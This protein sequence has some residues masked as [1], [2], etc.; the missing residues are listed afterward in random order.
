MPLSVF[1]FGIF[2]LHNLSKTTN[3]ML[4]F[5]TP[6]GY[7]FYTLTSRS[8]LFKTILKFIL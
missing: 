5:L 2:L 3:K 1:K 6:F 8:V 7:N 4:N